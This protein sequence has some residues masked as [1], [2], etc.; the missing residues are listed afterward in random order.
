MI[1]GGT[2]EHWERM[3]RLQSNY[4]MGKFATGG[5]RF[6]GKDIQK[7]EDGSF[8]STRSSTSRRRSTLFL[9]P[10]KEV[11]RGTPDADERRLLLCVA[12][13]VAYLG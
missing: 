13:S 1:H 12:S 4:K 2:K 10:E 7:N 3:N 9:L 5:G 11:G 8:T 6:S